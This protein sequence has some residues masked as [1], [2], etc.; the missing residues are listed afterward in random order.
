[1]FSI[2]LSTVYVQSK[3]Q[4]TRG[5]LW[6]QG[7]AEAAVP[8]P[9]GLRTP[10]ASTAGNQSLL[11]LPR[12]LRA[13]PPSHTFCTD[14][15]TGYAW[16]PSATRALSRAPFGDKGAQRRAVPA[17]LPD[18]GLRRLPLRGAL[19]RRPGSAFRGSCCSAP[20][21]GAQSCLGGDLPLLPGL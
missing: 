16:R 8:V 10:P 20:P 17:P 12:L 9:P 6:R 21:T 3:G 7:R 4:A 13:V 2:Q 19:R 15:K 1:M 18:F 11:L 5:A 14:Q